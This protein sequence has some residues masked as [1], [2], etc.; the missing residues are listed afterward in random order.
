MG[1]SEAT[2]LVP[3]DNKTR[4]EARRFSRALPGHLGPLRLWSCLRLLCR[5]LCPGPGG[6][7]WLQSQARPT[8]IS[9]IT[10]KAYCLHSHLG[11]G[12]SVWGSPTD[13]R[14]RHE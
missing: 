12:V 2:R 10:S 5:T 4:G 11:H 1:Q 6:F 14:P 7:L 9:R 3:E 13:G 8:L